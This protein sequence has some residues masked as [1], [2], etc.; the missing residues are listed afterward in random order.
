MADAHVVQQFLRPRLDGRFFRPRGARAQHRAQDACLG[1]QVAPDHHVF[2]GADKL[3]NRRMF[4]NV[5]ANP[6]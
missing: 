3:A 6:A 2:D 5:R 1:T 4:W